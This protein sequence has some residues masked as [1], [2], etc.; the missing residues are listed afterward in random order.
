MTRRPRVGRRRR[1]G[2]R[3]SASRPAGRWFC[4]SLRASRPG[5][6]RASVPTAGWPRCFAAVRRLEEVPHPADHQAAERH[7]QRRA[8]GP[9][10][11][12]HRCHQE[13]LEQHT[14]ASTTT[15]SEGRVSR[16][17]Q[18][19]A[20]NVVNASANTTTPK[21]TPLKRWRSSGARR[22][23]EKRS[24]KRI[25]RKSALVNRRP[26]APAGSIRFRQAGSQ[27]LPRPTMSSSAS[28]MVMASS[29]WVA[30]PVG[31]GRAGTAAAAPRTTTEP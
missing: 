18:G 12:A 21:S 29:A 31:R 16:P 10:D 2:R 13:V 26:N 17:E 24:N 22:G 9:D 15:P 20:R 1:S 19:G 30:P 6:G 4:S 14:S 28:S 27:V 5:A 3:S 7:D 25:R 11:Q 23:R 8:E